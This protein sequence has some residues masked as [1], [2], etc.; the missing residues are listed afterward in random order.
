MS[1]KCD[2]REN[3]VLTVILKGINEF[4]FAL[5]VVTDVLCNVML[6]YVFELREN[7]LREGRTFRVL[8]NLSTHIP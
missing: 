2:F 3:R 7:R 4:R 6:L 5:S 1:R 8:L